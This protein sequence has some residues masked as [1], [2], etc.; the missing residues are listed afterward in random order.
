MNTRELAAEYRLQRWAEL[1][2]ECKESGLS[3]KAYCKS[4]NVHENT[5]FYWRRKLRE[6]LY[7]E[8]VKDQDR[9]TELILTNPQEKSLDTERLVP[10]KWVQINT[11]EATGT[12]AN[13]NNSSSIKISRDGWTIIIDSHVDTGLLTETLRAVSQTCY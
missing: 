11:K 13:T 3:I 10:V 2:R 1:I 7:T 9:K 6:T 4:I 12:V 5:Y 8:I